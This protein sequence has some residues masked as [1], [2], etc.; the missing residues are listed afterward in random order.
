[1]KP[2]VLV[3]GA[4]AYVIGGAITFAVVRWIGKGSPEL[5]FVVGAILGTELGAV[6]HHRQKNATNSIA[7][8]SALGVT[9]AVTAAAMG[10]VLHSVFAPFSYADLSI[11]TSAL[12]SFVFP[13]VLFDTMWSSLSKQKNA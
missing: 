4:V 5:T 3:V 10:V 11:G 9:L 8:K 2:I 12:G 1:M 7:V 13:F 6:V